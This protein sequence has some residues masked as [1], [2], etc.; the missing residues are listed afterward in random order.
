M[1]THT[2]IA[3]RKTDAH[4]HTYARTEQD[5]RSVALILL[6]KMNAV[7]KRKL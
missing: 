7:A 1:T 5:T 4:A 2:I 6:P 3:F